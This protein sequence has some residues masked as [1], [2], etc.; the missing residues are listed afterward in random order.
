MDIGRPFSPYDMV[1]GLA[2]GLALFYV[3]LAVSRRSGQPRTIL[4]AFLIK[5]V[6]CVVYCF[7]VTFVAPGAD[8]IYYQR[9]GIAYSGALRSALANGDI[10]YPFTHSFLSIGQGATINFVNLSG[11]VHSILFDSFLGSSMFFAVIGLVGQLLIY[12]TFVSYYP[13]PR[14]RLWWQIGV[15]YFPSLTFWSA[16]LVKDGLGIFG[17]GCVLWAVRNLL[18][19]VRVRYVLLVVTGVYGLLLFR[20]PVAGSLFVAIVP[21]ILM[22]YGGSPSEDPAESLR[23]LKMRLG[24]AGACVLGIALLGLVAPA[25]SISELP[26][27][28]AKD[29]A[30]YQTDAGTQSG[31]AVGV[32]A[33]VHSASWGEIIRAWPSAMFL[34]LY[35]P[36]PWEASSVT[37]LGAALENVILLLLSVRAICYLVIKPALRQ[38]V[39]RSP[40]FLT[41]VIF[42]ASFAFGVGVSS[43]NLGTISRY[44][45]PII[46]FLA[47]IFI[48]LEY[49]LLRLRARQE[50]ADMELAIGRRR[51]TS[52]RSGTALL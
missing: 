5:M 34:A 32:T 26:T 49:H 20:P 41:C 28:I 48:I 37:A 9:A 44:R 15:L 19:H 27:T 51:S 33:L 50:T 8:S 2:F 36:F 43:P 6:A 3:F 4:T 24:L 31:V 39:I 35:R 45:I 42:L 52:T 23:Q 7:F 1:F 30:T 18:L 46:P 40:L 12:R 11:I 38:E 29:S 13:D 16:G 21:W 25:Y 17:M 47:G 14:I 22:S 10:S